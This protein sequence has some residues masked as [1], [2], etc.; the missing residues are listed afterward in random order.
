MQ[1]TRRWSS[2]W[3][4]SQLHWTIVRLNRLTNKAANGKVKTSPGLLVK[5][6]AIAR[7]D[8]AATQ[9]DIV[10]DTSLARIA[11]NVSGASAWF[12]S[13][14]EHPVGIQGRREL[15]PGTNP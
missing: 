14:R 7:A 3:S 5:P 10:A 15:S 8:A 13:S 1:T 4:P 2:L 6:R 12:T 11:I 9:L